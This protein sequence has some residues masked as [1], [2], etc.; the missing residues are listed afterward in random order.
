MARAAVGRLA[1]AVALVVL[2][3]ASTAG[4]QVAP[5]SLQVDGEGGLFHQART[6]WLQDDNF[7]A[8]RVSWALGERFAIDGGLTM[9]LAGITADDAARLE[10]ALH[11]GGRF[12]PWTGRCWCARWAPYVRA[13]VALVAASQL[14]SNYDFTLGVG[15][16]GKLSPRLGWFVELDAIERV[17]DYDAFALHLALG[18]SVSKLAF[19]R[20]GQ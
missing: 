1:L 4:A 16:W 6:G 2:A 18:L 17:G 9:D 19:W 10:P 14:F 8:L 13:D 7:V 15:H 11:V 12:R 20:E 3:T 5:S